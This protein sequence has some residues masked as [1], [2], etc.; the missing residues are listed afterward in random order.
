MG[1][2]LN[3]WFIM[4]DLGVAAFQETVTFM[5]K[6]F[7]RFPPCTAGR[8]IAKCFNSPSEGS[9]Y[10]LKFRLILLEKS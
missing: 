9:L 2:P 7:L 4:D 10:Y 1:V 3:G 5:S 8:T 6:S